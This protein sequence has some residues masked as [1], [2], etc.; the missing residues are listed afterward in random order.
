MPRFKRRTKII[1]IRLSEDEHD[2]LQNYCAK[3]G[4]PLSELI[5][6]ALTQF[7]A[8]KNDIDGKISSLD[9]EVARLS[10]IVGLTRLEKTQ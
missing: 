9:R 8:P 10:A 5:R 2:Q 1:S 4:V 7:T 3:Q 6:D